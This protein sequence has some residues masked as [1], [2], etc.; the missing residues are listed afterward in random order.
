LD[1]SSRR[2][3]LGGAHGGVTAGMSSYVVADVM[4]VE[5]PDEERV[6]VLA[7]DD[8]E[9]S[10]FTCPYPSDS[11]ELTDVVRVRSS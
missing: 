1:T 6:S 10:V 4:A 7:M 11:S 9:S 2:V 3:R 8:A 5:W